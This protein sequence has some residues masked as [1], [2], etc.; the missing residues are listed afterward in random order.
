ARHLTEQEKQAIVAFETALFTAQ[1]VSDEAGRLQ[2]G[3]ARGGPGALLAGPFFVGVNYPSGLDPARPPFDPPAFHPFN[4][5][6]DAPGAARDIS[7]ARRAIA[8]GQ[9]IFN[10]RPIVIAGVAGLNNQT[11]PSGV[12]VPDPFT[13]TC[14]SCHDTP[15]AG[16]HSVKVPLDLG[17][18]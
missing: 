15:N 5:W 11:F 17:L 12:M 13:G 4:A 3:G 18:T 8:R 14:T 16:N 1:A 6:L 10:T 7:R 2:A 9:E